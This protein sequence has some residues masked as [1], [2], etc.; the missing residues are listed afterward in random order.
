[1]ESLNRTLES[2]KKDLQETAHERDMH[3]HLVHKHVETEV[4][5]G[6]E[7]RK[8]LVYAT[9]TSRLVPLNPYCSILMKRGKRT[10][11]ERQERHSAGIF[12]KCLIL[13]YN[14]PC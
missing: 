3:S 5:L 6:Q 12:E 4:K 2:T 9:D 8:L 7:A 11:E 10:R 14:E 1:M 13:N